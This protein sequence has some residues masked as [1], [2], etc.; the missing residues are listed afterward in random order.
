MA[1]SSVPPSP[2]RPQTPHRLPSLTDHRSIADTWRAFWHSVTTNDRHASHDSPY[3]TGSHVPLAQSR[4]APL[5]SVATSA[6]DSRGDL[7][8]GPDSAAPFAKP[9]SGRASPSTP[10]SPG[11]MSALRRQSTD[12]S[13]IDKNPPTEIQMQNFNDG[14]PPPPPVSHSWKRIE[15]W[16]EDNYT[17]LLDNLCEGA[18]QND[19]NELEHDLDCTLPADVR[20]SLM[21]HDGQ[22]R[23]GLP[24]GIL[25]GCMLLDCEE[26][27]EEWQ[28]WR[29]VNEQ[30]LQRGSP[31]PTSQPPPQ[32]PIKAFASTS[33]SS[34]S[35]IPTADQQQRN[36]LWR[37]ELIARQDSQPPNAVQKAY[38]HPGW[39]PLARDW[40]GNCIAVDLA[41]GPAGKCGQIILFGRDYDCKFVIARSWAAFLAAV[42]DDFGTPE[43]IFVDEENHEFRFRQFRDADPPYLEVLRWRCDQRH[44]RRQQQQRRRGAPPNGLRIN[45]NVNNAGAPD[46]MNGS[47]YTS[48]TSE[49]GRSPQRFPLGK[50]SATTASP[51]R[52]HVSSPLARVTEEAP[53]P[54]KV[55]TDLP[56]QTTGQ[57]PQPQTEKLVSV[58]TP[59]PSGD[60]G[61]AL[62][63]NGVDKDKENVDLGNK[64]E[65]KIVGSPP[66]PTIAAALEGEDVK[67]NVFA[68]GGDAPAEEMKSVV[69]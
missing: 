22:E 3:R 59:R 12:R 1:P 68:V 64:M 41:P 2:N 66:P 35:Q 10:Y 37:D 54:I 65:S 57:K 46:L 20:E 8:D 34:N 43:K 19:V 44:G 56:A 26:I 24:T 63:L 42:A 29:T 18:T 28:N 39:V 58:D 5:T 53:R 33:S 32:I 7:T 55:H 25:F 60:F 31:R 69:L 27:V 45:S 49:R 6:F 16:T 52:Q 4:H 17:E 61:N 11:R 13:S 9:A 48:P 30:F 51:L 36:S 21:I 15:R 50:H 67:A 47:P 38:A 23:G 14:L 40:G 62:G